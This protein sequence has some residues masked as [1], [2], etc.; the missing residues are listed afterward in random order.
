MIDE[1]EQ[2]VTESEASTFNLTTALLLLL[3]LL[4]VV[5]GLLTYMLFE[6]SGGVGMGASS[7]GNPVYCIPITPTPTTARNIELEQLP[8]S[9]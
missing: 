1:Q 7:K 9:Y 5:V 4:V 8:F 3:M 6:S 2:V